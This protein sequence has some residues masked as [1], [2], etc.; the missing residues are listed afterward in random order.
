M[1]Q[2]PWDIL[3][4]STV[5][6]TD[7]L[8]LWP[9]QTSPGVELNLREEMYRLLYGAAD[10]IA[11]GVIGMFRR[12]RLDANGKKVKCPCRDTITDEPDK[13]FYCRTCIGLGYLWDERELVYYK[14][15]DTLRKTDEMFFYVE[16]FVRPSIGDYIV[17][18]IRDAEGVITPPGMREKLY[19]IIEAEPFR[20]D[21]G[22]IEYWRCRTVYEREWSVWY[23]VQS[24]QH[25]P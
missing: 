15:D 12:A 3:Y 19:R 5:T 23:G 10:E 2:N 17:E 18:L 14:S 8:S 11:K 13:D 25:E 1:P 24:R 21:V 6:S 16:Y 20:S 7:L 9:V 4:P 22:R